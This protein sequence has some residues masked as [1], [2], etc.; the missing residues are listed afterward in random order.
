MKYRIH[1]TKIELYLKK[2][3]GNN[4][5]VQKSYSKRV[6]FLRLSYKII[7]FFYV[8]YIALPVVAQAIPVIFLEKT[9]SNSSLVVTSACCFR[10]SLP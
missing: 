3:H 10:S 6:S 9:F 7:Q 4:S 8:L 2:K 1:K 5:T